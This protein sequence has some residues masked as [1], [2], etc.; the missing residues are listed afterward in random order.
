MK[1]KFHI[2]HLLPKVI[3]KGISRKKP[4]SLDIGIFTTF[5]FFHGEKGGAFIAYIYILDSFKISI[6][7]LYDQVMPFLLLYM[8]YIKPK[9][10]PEL[11][12]SFM[13]L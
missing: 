3:F 4:A 2:R 6:F 1:S 5:S 8:M 12:G 7:I 13:K 10:P 11:L 9:N